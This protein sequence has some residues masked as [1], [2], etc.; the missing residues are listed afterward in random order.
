MVMRKMRWMLAALFLCAYTGA[1]LAQA[2]KPAERHSVNETLE[3][4]L[5][6]MEKLL[7]GVVDVMPADKYSFAPTNGEF[8]GVR[9]FAKQ[10]KHVAAV[11]YIIGAA[12]LGEAPPADAADERGPDA[13][14]TKDEVTKYLKDSLAYLHKAVAAI[15]EK[16]LLEPIK[17]PFGQGAETRLGL[18]MSALAHSSNHYGQMVEY[19]RMN[20]IIPPASQ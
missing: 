16:N 19:L 3:K 20:G 12:I 8:R 4:R 11:H 2:D 6:G 15:D 7:L 9:N 10:L 5:G 13:V 17:S 1:A 14:K 18:V